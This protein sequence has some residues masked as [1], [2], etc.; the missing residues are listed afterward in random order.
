M[1]RVLVTGGR[2]YGDARRVFGELDILHRSFGVSVVIHGAARGADSLAARWATVRGV[3]EIACPADW[4]RG[5]HAAGPVRNSDMLRNHK[6]D[7]VLAFPGGRGTEDMMRK[8]LAANVTL[9]TV[10]A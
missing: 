9:I 10:L 3:E 6:P 8:A 4:A 2:D 7:I 5:G 1:K